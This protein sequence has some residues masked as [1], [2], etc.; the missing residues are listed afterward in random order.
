P[1]PGAA[2]SRWRRGDPRRCAPAR[3]FARACH[4]P[5]AACLARSWQGGLPHPP[6]APGTRPAAPRCRRTSAP[7]P[8]RLPFLHLPLQLFQLLLQGD[9][10]ELPADDDFLELFQVQD[11]LLE[12]A[13]G[14]LQVAHY[15]LVGAHV[16]EDADGAD[17][18]PVRVAEGGGVERRRD[19]LAR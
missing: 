10:L 5:G 3:R 14:L 7:P 11:L 2:D 19:D 12:L 8:L 4:V 17:H 18:F 15:L 13:F 6:T 16:A 1:P 9:H